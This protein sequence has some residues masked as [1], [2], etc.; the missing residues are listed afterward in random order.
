MELGLFFSHTKVDKGFENAEGLII[1]KNTCVFV[2]YYVTCLRYF[3]SL[4][5]D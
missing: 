3:S 1:T 4:T 2:F 5:K